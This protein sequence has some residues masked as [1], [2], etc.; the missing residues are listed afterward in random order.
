SVHDTACDRRDSLA[1]CASLLQKCSSRR[2]SGAGFVPACESQGDGGAMAASLKARFAKDVFVRSLQNLRHG[3]L[4]LVCP[5]ETLRFG[6]IHSDLHATIAV[7][8]DDFFAN[9]IIGGD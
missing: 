5:G 9:A 7:S 1:G 8:D 4:E 3:S 2:S 6:D